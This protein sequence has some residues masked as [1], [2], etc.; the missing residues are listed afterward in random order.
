MN[1][2][3]VSFT[4]QTSQVHLPGRQAHVQNAVADGDRHAA[5][6]GA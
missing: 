2:S 1:K 4:R 5:A 3:V 6:V